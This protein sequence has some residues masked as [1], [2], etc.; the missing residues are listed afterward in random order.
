MASIKKAVET[1]LLDSILPQYGNPMVQ[2]PRWDESQKMFLFGDYESMSGNRFYRGIRFC[3][4]LVILEKVGQY[5]TWTYIDGLELYAFNGRKLTL[6][7]SKQYSKQF[8]DQ[9]F[10]R[11]ESEA[12][13]RNY[14]LGMCKTAGTTMTEEEATVQSKSL[15]EQCYKS[16]LDPDFNIHLTQILPQLESKEF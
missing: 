6:I 3:N 16:F 15:V 1:N 8:Y 9:E 5:H 10:I 4:N 12:M 7:Q 11:S 13:V 2:M 14:I